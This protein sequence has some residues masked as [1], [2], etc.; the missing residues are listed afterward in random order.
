MTRYSTYSEYKVSVAERFIRTLKTNIFRH[1][2]L[3]G[4]HNWVEN[5]QEQMDNYNDTK[6]STIG[7]TPTA[8]RNISNEETL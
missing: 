7:M 4:T 6:Q 5:L 8:A 2:L 3:K 1:F